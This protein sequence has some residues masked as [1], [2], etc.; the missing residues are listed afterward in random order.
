MSEKEKVVMAMTLTQAE[1]IA[2][3]IN[4]LR[5]GDKQAAFNAMPEMDIDTLDLLIA[6]CDAVL[7]DRRAVKE[8][9]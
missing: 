6:Y 1:E 9:D 4:H 2:Q 8:H 5:N 3:V 7:K